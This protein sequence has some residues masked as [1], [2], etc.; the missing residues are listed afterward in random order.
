MYSEAFFNIWAREDLSPP[1][2]VGIASLNPVKLSLMWSR[3][4]LSKALWCALLSIPLGKLN[5]K[6]INCQKLVKVQWLLTV[7]CGLDDRGCQS[8]PSHIFPFFL[9]GG[10]NCWNMCSTQMA[11][12]MCVLDFK[13]T[14]SSNKYLKK[15]K[16]EKYPSLFFAF[17]IWFDWPH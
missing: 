8:R 17:S 10:R 7:G 13:Y 12:L 6:I 1:F 3:R 9:R 15:K 16:G 5:K 2:I 14:Y 11:I 4:F